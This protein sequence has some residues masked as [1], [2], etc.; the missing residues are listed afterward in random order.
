M[1]KDVNSED[2][3]SV[4]NKCVENLEK[5]VNLKT[6]ADRALYVGSIEKLQLAVC[7]EEISM[8]YFIS[9]YTGSIPLLVSVLEKTQ[10]QHIWHFAI[11]IMEKMVLRKSDGTDHAQAFV[12]HGAVEH[13][14][15]LI[16]K[17]QQSWGDD[18]ICSLYRV[19]V[20]VGEED[21]KFPVKAR[22]I[23][24]LPVILS[25]L[26]T[27]AKKYKVLNLVLRLLKKIAMSSVNA[28]KLSKD[29]LPKELFRLLDSPRKSSLIPILE[30]ISEATRAKTAARQFIKEDV[31]SRTLFILFHTKCD[32]KNNSVY[33]ICKTI[34]RIL[35]HLTQLRGGREKLSCGSTI[36]YLLSWS[37]MVLPIPGRRYDSLIALVSTLVQRCSAPRLLPVR[38][39]VNPVGFAFSEN[40]AVESDNSDGRNDDVVSVASS[41]LSSVDSGTDSEEEMRVYSDQHVPQESESIQKFSIFFQELR[42]PHSIVCEDIDLYKSSFPDLPK[43]HSNVRKGKSEGPSQISEKEHLLESARQERRSQ[44]FLDS[45][46]LPEAYQILSTATVSMS[47]LVKL[48]YPDMY[49]ST[50]RLEPLTK[51]ST[52]DPFCVRREMYKHAEESTRSD[53]VY[54][55][56]YNLDSFINESSSNTTSQ[57]L[58]NTDDQHIYSDQRHIHLNFEARFES[59]NLRKVFWKGNQEYDLIL[60]PDINSK[61]HTQWFYFQVSGMEAGVPYVFNTVNMEKPTSQFNEGMCPVMFSVRNHKEKKQGW[62]RVGSNICYY[63]NHYTHPSS[64]PYYTLTFSIHFQHSNDI[65]YFAYHYPYTLTTLQTHIYCWSNSYDSSLIY[66]K[67]DGLCKTLSGNIMPLLTITANPVDCNREYIFLTARIHPGESNSSWTMKGLLD[68]LLCSKPSAQRIREMYIFKI[69]PMLNPDG[70]V[71][72]SHRCSLTGQDLNRQWITPNIQL[73]PTIYH[74]KALISYLCSKNRKPQVFCDFHGHS[75]R[76]NVFFFG[77]NP[78][79]SW[80]ASN[81]MKEDCESFKVLPVLM[82]HL[83]PAFSLEDCVFS[84]ERCREST[85]RVAVWRQYDVPLSYTMECSYGGCDQGLYAGF[86]I[87][88]AQLEETGM[89]LCHCFAK[90]AVDKETGLVR[91]TLPLD[92]HAFPKPRFQKP[93]SLRFGST[94]LSESDE[95]FEDFDEDQFL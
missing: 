57:M 39:L 27:Y 68:F 10:D 54:E 20:K 6:S 40:C 26:K 64:K 67:S 33:G 30:V 86:H 48:A 46:S 32:N 19:A 77:C 58:A 42:Q 84:V 75:R 70:V 94:S 79:Q 23:G 60:S 59:G 91:S 72:G 41:N 34:L 50:A 28:S 69:V 95:D 87:G 85:G 66:F 24:L 37:Q 62:T 3:L 36:P 89:K 16:L 71:N 11:L 14:L 45:V 43:R 21:K 51:L 73:H 80:L 29:G 76:S 35:V 78:E 90:M 82:H 56:I 93:P 18:F 2:P 25:Q 31:I 15:K 44:K 49:A 52:P 61:T 17:C 13:L 88:I 5:L 1:E 8:K 47:P 9:N 63:R 92:L 55:E 74:T 65:C 81:L 7:N 12:F 4:V 83:A 38:K 22:F 53:Y